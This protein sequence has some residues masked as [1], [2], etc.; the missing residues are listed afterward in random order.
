MKRVIVLLC[1][2]YLVIAYGTAFA[3]TDDAPLSFQANPD[4]YKVLAENDEMRVVLAI[5]PA[6]YKDKPHSHPKAAAYT[7]NDCHARITT[8]DGKSR[9]V[10]NKAGTARINPAVPSHTFQNIGETECRELKFELKK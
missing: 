7:F 1:A 2:L 3:G 10:I 6:G 4:V 5:W 8:P 9:E